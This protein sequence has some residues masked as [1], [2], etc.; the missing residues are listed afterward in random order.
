MTRLPTP[1]SDNGTWGQILNSYLTTSLNSDGTLKD[2]V[3]TA[4]KLDASVRTSLSKADSAMQRAANLSDLTDASAARNNLGLGAAAVMTPTAIATDPALSSTYATSAGVK[5]RALLAGA[6]TQDW[7][8]KSRYGVMVHYTWGDS[9]YHQTIFSDGTVPASANALAN[10]FDATRF[11]AD[12]AAFGAEYVIFTAWH[13]A[14]H[15]LYPSAVMD[16]VIPGHSTTRDVIQD[17]IN[18]LRP[19]GIRLM[20]YVHAT[21]GGVLTGPEQTATGWLDATNNYAVWRGFIVNLVTELGQRYGDQLDGMWLDA[22]RGS[23]FYDRFPDPS[24]LRDA[25]RMGS[26]TRVIVCNNA[27]DSSRPT[28]VADHPVREYNPPPADVNNW[29]AGYSGTVTVASSNIDWWATAAAGGASRFSY[30]ATDLF[31]FVVLQAG[32]NIRGGGIALGAGSYAG[33]PTSLWEDGVETGMKALAA[34]IAPISESL[35][36]VIPSSS[37]ITPNTVTLNTLS[38]YVA[39]T[40]MDGHTEYIHVL[41]PPAGALTLAVPADGMKFTSA[42]N[43]VTGRPL[44]IEITHTGTYTLTLNPSDTWSATDTVIKLTRDTGV[45]E[46]LW[47]GATQWITTDTAT[48]VPTGAGNR[49][50]EWSMSSTVNSQIVVTFSPPSNWK[51]FAADLYW[52]QTGAGTGNVVFTATRSQV[53]SGVDL[54]TGD[55]ASP[56]SGVFAMP[57]TTQTLVVTELFPELTN[58]PGAINHIRVP[59]LATN[60]GDTGPDAGILGIRLRRLM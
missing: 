58:T 39:T 41:K 32:S 36:N 28:T 50:A 7:Y 27:D 54:N 37:Y 56:T 51:I 18:A 12:I 23:L 15:A 29:V 30:S 43:L 22:T 34:L 25:L 35:T 3:V 48:L 24:I 1:G 47:L 26:A 53:A 57:G 33:S 60:G 19:H 20:L 11:A 9:S 10:A 13:Y 16:A 2:S 38:R 52:L 49:M 31:R 45:S 4:N 44:N 21:V 59:R 6:P 14:M 40:S 5:E 42:T 17:L 46:A 8:Q 55:E